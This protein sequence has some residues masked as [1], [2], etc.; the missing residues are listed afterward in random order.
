M[1][2]GWA[3]LTILFTFLVKQFLPD[4]QYGNSPDYAEHEISEITLPQQFYVQQMT[5][6]RADVAT[7][8]TDNQVHTAPFAL[9]THNAVGHVADEKTCKY[10]PG[11]KISN[12]L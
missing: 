9:T 4:P 1:S 3:S 5:D 2:D 12:M 8:D 11:C 7:D 6:E 10:R